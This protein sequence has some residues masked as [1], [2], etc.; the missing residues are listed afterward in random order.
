[1]FVKPDFARYQAVSQQIHTIFQ[2]YTALIEPLSLDDDYLDITE[3]QALEGSATWIAQTIR[4]QIYQTTR[5]TASAGVSPNKFLA[6]L[7]S[8]ENKPDGLRVFTPEQAEAFI[9]PIDDERFHGIGSKTFEK[10]QPLGVYTGADQRTVE[11]SVLTA[12]FGKAGRFY[13]QIA[14]GEDEHP[15]RAHR[16][17]KSI[18][19]KRTFARD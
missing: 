8:D 14:R 4:K 9:S 18:G 3:C 1:V 19:H 7:A 5:L 2:H 15:V 12:N 6:K 13:Y 11:L 16:V 10:M 17:R